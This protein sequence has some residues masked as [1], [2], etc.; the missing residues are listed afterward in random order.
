MMRADWPGIAALRRVVDHWTDTDLVCLS[1]ALLEGNGGTLAEDELYRQACVVREKLIEA[2]VMLGLWELVQRGEVDLQV[3][4]A[5]ELAIVRRTT[6]RPAV[7]ELDARL[8]RVR[9]RLH[10]EGEEP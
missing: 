7:G 4:A 9:Q 3:T 8:V 5:N 6:P 10:A 1:L 2:R